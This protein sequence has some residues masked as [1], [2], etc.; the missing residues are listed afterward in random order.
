M[1]TFRRVDVR[2]GRMSGGSAEILAGLEP[3]T[4]VATGGA[5]ALK[6]ELFRDEMA[7]E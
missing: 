6:S 7:G 3:G 2:V 5:F 4:P 1:T